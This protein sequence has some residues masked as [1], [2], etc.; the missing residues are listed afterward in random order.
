VTAWTQEQLAE[1]TELERHTQHRIADILT[2]LDQ[3]LSLE[4]IAARGNTH[5]NN[6]RGWL[7]DWRRLAAREGPTGKT[8]AANFA[9]MVK[10]VK[11]ENISPELGR[12]I[13]DYLD[14][15]RAVNPE[16]NVD[17]P[18]HPGYLPGPG[19]KQLRVAT[20]AICPTCHLAKPCYCE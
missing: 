6:I 4:K 2:G 11:D 10:F 9:R 16:I 14:Q 7:A 1:L 13:R 20:D 5:V 17:T 3:G 8:D 15:L 18:S 12:G 19:R